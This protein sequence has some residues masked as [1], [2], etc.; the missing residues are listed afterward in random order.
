MDE[1]IFGDKSHRPNDADLAQALGRT[2]RYWDALIV[3]A[4]EAAPSA[5]ATWKHYGGKSGWTFVVRG[6]RSNVIYMR[7]LARH[8]IAAFAFGAAAVEAA[9]QSDLPAPIIELI[10]TAPQYTE[11]RA[12]RI[13]V[14]TAADAAI[15]KR[16]LTIKV[17]N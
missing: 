3:A 5:T 16:L 2:K 17:K 9:L 15:V 7:P 12:V 11:G 8:F 10:R 13:A 14:Q 6:K 1:P 4:Q